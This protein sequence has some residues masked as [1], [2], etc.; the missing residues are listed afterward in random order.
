MKKFFFGNASFRSPAL[1][2]L[3]LLNIQACTGL[4]PL[5]PLDPARKPEVLEGCRRLFL[6]GK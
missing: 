5:I 2:L 6:P 1:F 4:K 3:L